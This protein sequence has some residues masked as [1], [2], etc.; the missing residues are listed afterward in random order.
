MMEAYSPARHRVAYSLH[1]MQR[2][3]QRGVEL[4]ADDIE[5]LESAIEKLRPAFEVE[6]QE[7]YWITVRRPGCRFRVLYDIRLHCLV[8]VWPT[9]GSK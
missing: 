8:T 6:G 7:R 2:A 3:E 5:R 9:T 4:T 1:L